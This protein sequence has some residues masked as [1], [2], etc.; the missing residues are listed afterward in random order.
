MNLSITIADRISFVE[1]IGFPTTGMSSS[2]PKIFK[3]YILSNENRKHLIELDSLLNDTG[4]TIF[5]FRGSINIF[6]F[7]RKKTGLFVKFNEI[8]ISKIIPTDLNKVGN[9]YFHEHLSIGISRATLIK[10]SEVINNM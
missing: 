8:D 3:D 5:L 4:K 10:I 1:L 2:N 9:L 7:M 6:K